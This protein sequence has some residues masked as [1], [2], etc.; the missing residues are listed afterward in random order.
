M[1][2]YASPNSQVPAI[3]VHELY[4]PKDHNAY[5]S[6]IQTFP[7][8]TKEAY[9]TLFN[10]GRLGRSSLEDMRQLRDDQ[11]L[12][13]PR[14]CHL[15][16]A[17]NL[18]EIV[19]DRYLHENPSSPDYYARVRHHALAARVPSKIAPVGKAPVAGKC[20]IV[21]GPPGIGKAA[22]QREVIKRFSDK[23]FH[24]HWKVSDS[25]EYAQQLVYIEVPFSSNVDTLMHMMLKQIDA[26]SNGVTWQGAQGPA[27]RSQLLKPRL[28]SSATTRALGLVYVYG[29]DASALSARGAIESLDLLQQFAAFTGASVV[30]SSTYA[31]WNLLDGKLPSALKLGSGGIHRFDYIPLGPDWHTLVRAFLH[32]HKL[33]VVRE[34]VDPQTE[35]QIPGLLQ[36]RELNISEVVQIVPTWFEVELMAKALGVPALLFDFLAEL[37]TV[38][39]RKPRNQDLIE[40]AD[41][42]EASRRYMSS[43]RF[44]VGNLSL[45]LSKQTCSSKETMIFADWITPEQRAHL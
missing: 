20:C 34:N 4:L 28:F 32:R 7:K 35:A 9:D 14:T 18:V 6:K 17:E 41:L 5:L 38:M 37:W 29:I 12:F 10:K 22:F 13:I 15:E 31:I 39:K 44:V 43:K 19:A 8:S 40:E 2:E 21:A 24:E 45:L 26:G 42:T 23:K 16:A 30:C 27:A 3:K 36:L 1:S 25:L 33:R 11:E